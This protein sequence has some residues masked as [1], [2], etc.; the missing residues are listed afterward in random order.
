M[1]YNELHASLSISLRGC[2][3]VNASVRGGTYFTVSRGS[4][5][6]LVVVDMMQRPGT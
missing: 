6:S 4:N 3:C 2:V 5:T 1:I